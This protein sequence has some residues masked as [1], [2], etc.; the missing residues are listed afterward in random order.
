V[1]TNPSNGGLLLSAKYADMKIAGDDSKI[2]LTFY[3]SHCGKYKS[4]LTLDALRLA[5]FNQVPVLYRNKG[6]W[7]VAEKHYKNALDIDSIGKLLSHIPESINAH[8]ERM[9]K[10]KDVK[11][12]LDDFIQ[13]WENHYKLKK[14]QKQYDSK[15]AKLKS[16]YF[17]APGQ[18]ICPAESAYKAFQCVTYN[19][20]HEGRNTA[21]RLE[22]AFFKGGD[23]SL[24]WM[25]ELLTLSA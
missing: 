18:D 11:L 12:G 8:N 10:L 25:E 22:N 13:M 4:I 23:D 5:C 9:E 20:T 3:T 2:N 16:T 1:L 7:L 19:N 24:E 17:A 21:M 14:E 15:I 6:R